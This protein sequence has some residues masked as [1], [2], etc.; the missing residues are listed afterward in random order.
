M[1]RGTVSIMQRN[2]KGYWLISGGIAVCVLVVVAGML[3]PGSSK[4]IV[5]AVLTVGIFLVYPRLASGALKPTFASANL[6]VDQTGV[7]ADDAPVVRRE[8]IA[9][10]Y[11][12][13]AVESRLRRFNDSGKTFAITLPAYPL[14]VE[15]IKRGGGQVNI[16]PGNEQG[17]AAIL[18]ALGFPV[19]KSAPYYR[20]KT[21]ARQWAITVVV[22]M[23]FLAALLGFSYYKST[24]H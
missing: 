1:F 6:Y 13:P 16:D 11:I 18:T 23:V 4:M 17:A 9:Q 8:D 7:Y 15:L 10:A 22:V 3:L 19:T 5:F 14:T 21:S 24:G 20:P 2:T 12:R